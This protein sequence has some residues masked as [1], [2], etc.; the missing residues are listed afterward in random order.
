MAKRTITPSYLSGTERIEVM[1]KFVYEIV[2]YKIYKDRAELV[3]NKFFSSS[4]KLKIK[5]DIINI[6]KSDHTIS[7]QIFWIGAP[8]N[9]ILSNNLKFYEK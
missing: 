1:P 6:K 7:K 4:K 5:K 3:N 9:Y 2:V 8:E